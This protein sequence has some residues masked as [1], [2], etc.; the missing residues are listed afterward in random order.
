MT[1]LPP[2]NR[3]QRTGPISRQIAVW[4]L[5]TVVRQLSSH[6]RRSKSKE[7][8]RRSTPNPIRIWRCFLPH[9]ADPS[10]PWQIGSVTIC[11]ATLSG[12]IRRFNAPCW[13][14]QPSVAGAVFFLTGSAIVLVPHPQDPG[15]FTPARSRPL[16]PER[17]IAPEGTPRQVKRLSDPEGQKTPPPV[18]SDDPKRYRAAK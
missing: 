12:Q 1:K 10:T 15:R 17:Q 6:S 8:T 2:A 4:A 7:W 18:E 13:N 5:A 16:P 14:F 11:S 3:P 9:W